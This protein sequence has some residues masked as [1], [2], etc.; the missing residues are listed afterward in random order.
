MGWNHGL[1]LKAKAG[2]YVRK[3]FGP[4]SGANDLVNI[5]QLQFNEFYKMDVKK[6]NLPRP[7]AEILLEIQPTVVSFPWRSLAGCPFSQG[8]GGWWQCLRVRK[9]DKQDGDSV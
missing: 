9:R 3:A 1:S 5:H 2:L 4:Q 8:P 7:E 6:N